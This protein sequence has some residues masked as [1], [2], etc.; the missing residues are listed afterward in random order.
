MN[1]T[2]RVAR[3]I[4]TSPRFNLGTTVIELLVVAGVIAILA[5]ITISSLP[6]GNPRGY[7]RKDAEKLAIDIRVAQNNAI[8]GKVNGA[9]TPVNWG[10]NIRITGGRERQY[11]LFS[12]VN[13][14]CRYN[15]NEEVAIYA[16]EN[17][18]VFTQLSSSNGS[19]NELNFCF[20][21]PHGNA[22]I[23]DNNSDQGGYG[24]ARLSRVAPGGGIAPYRDVTMRVSGQISII[25]N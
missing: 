3:I 7:I 9:T 5:T 18:V 10:I 19:L 12:D 1:I 4:S 16:L 23:Y 6:R 11:I 24:T 13:G 14:N 22:F 21:V 2:S 15:N 20:S 8:V 25:G 17:G